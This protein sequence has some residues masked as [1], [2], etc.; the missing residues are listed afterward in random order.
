MKKLFFSAAV[1]L[2]SHISHLT[3]LHAQVQQEWVHTYNS[4]SFIQ[5]F[6]VPV[7]ELQI[8]AAGNAF[9]AGTIKNTGTGNDMAVVKIN[10]QG[11]RLWVATYNSTANKDDNV[12]GLVIDSA[13]NSYITGN[14]ATTSS[15]KDIVVVKFDTAGKLLWSKQYNGPDN[16][17][18]AGTH[19]AIDPWGNIIVIGVSNGTATNDDYVT[20]KYDSAGVQQWVKRYNGTGNGKDWA[21]TA[22]TDKYGNIY[23]AGESAGTGSGKDY[24][25]IKYDSAGVEKW[26]KRYNGTGND[27]DYVQYPNSIAID[28]LCNVYITGYSTGLDG[29]LDYATIKYDSLGNEK[30]VSRYSKGAGITDYGDALY[31]DKS[32]NVYVTGASEKTPGVNFDFA[33]VKYNSLGVQQWVAYYDGQGTGNQWDE[34]YA[35][36]ADD[37]LNVYILG[38]SIGTT[39][40]TDLVTI[41]YDSTGKQLWAMRYLNNGSDWPSAIRYAAADNS[42]YIGGAITTSPSGSFDMTVIKYKQVPLGVEALQGGNM[43]ISLFPNPASDV[44]TVVIHSNHEA[45]SATYS[46]VDY[47]GRVIAA[48]DNIALHTGDNQIKISTHTL[49]NGVYFVRIMSEKSSWNQKLVIVRNG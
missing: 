1:L 48:G 9:I 30:W 11:T 35:V 8:D 2:T 21:I 32:L 28:T 44:V 10:K 47:M 49:P 42:I 14:T 34:A 13:G 15:G 16:K 6:G 22:I 41:K 39:T 26:V 20:I 33:T 31:V 27:V 38:R 45:V 40:G 7:R 23:V 17:Y 36:V 24:L 12:S 25:T 5:D 43:N 3:S 37:S 29:T 19:L 4:P 46:M 18:D